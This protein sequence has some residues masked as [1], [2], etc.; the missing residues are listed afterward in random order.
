[1]IC[2]IPDSEAWDSQEEEPLRL[3]PRASESGQTTLEFAFSL[4]TITASVVTASWLIKTGWSRA[5]CAYLTF[6]GAKAALQMRVTPDRIQGR[7]LIRDRGEQIQ[8]TALCGD[9][10]GQMEAVKLNATH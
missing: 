4:V 1:M 10:T 2:S 6:E 9:Q 7:I 8:A 3:L 5:Q